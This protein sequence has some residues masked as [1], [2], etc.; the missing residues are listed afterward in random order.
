MKKALGL[1]SRGAGRVHPNPL[2]GAV[3]VKNGRVIGAGAHEKFGGPH[4]EVVAIRNAKHAPSVDGTVAA[5]ST[6]YVTLE[7]CPHTGKTPPC[8]DLILGEK[9]RK[10][11]IAAKDPNPIVSGRGILALK[12]KGLSVL[13]GVLETEAVEL[14][15]DYNHWMRKKTPYTIL[16]FA[17]SLDGKIA[18]SAGRSRWISSPA[19]RALA[20]KL[21]GQADAILVGIHTVLKDDPLL[22]VRSA[23]YRGAQP[24]KVILDSGLRLPLTARLFSKASPGA[25]LVATTASASNPKFEAL[26]SK[27]EVIRFSSKNGRVDLAQVMRFL[28]KRGVVSL[29]IEGGAEVIAD[30]LA[31]K[32][33]HEI[34]CFTAPI[35]L[36]GKKA[37]GSVGGRGFR[38]M[39]A[40]KLREVRIQTVGKDLLV[41]GKI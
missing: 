28:G 40:L 14:N 33:A 38:L 13:S 15:K 12:K 34:Y 16:K 20:H 39:N 11:V 25:V 35:L 5:G 3:L 31:Q 19:S 29:L 27:A 6:L 24:L 17:Q 2:V 30:A 9:I 21:R 8:T 4:A 41:R 22:S 10:V 36:G 32:V 1:A 37:P 26:R 7:P 18:D 23:A